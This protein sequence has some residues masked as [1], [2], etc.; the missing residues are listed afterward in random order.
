MARYWPTVLRDAWDKTYKPLGWDRKKAAVVLLAVGAI[1]VAGLQLGLA[2][3]ITTAAGY[4]WIAAPAGFAA[5]VLFVWGIIETQAKVYAE[6]SA[7]HTEAINSFESKISQLI[8]EK[9]LPEYEKW[10]QVHKYTL[11]EV[12]SLWC[13][14]EPGTIDTKE[15]KAQKRALESAIQTNK[16]PFIHKRHSGASDIE[17]QRNHPAWDTELRRTD[18]KQYALSIGQN[19]R[20]LRDA[21]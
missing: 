11:S 4:L 5:I 1:F 21:D 20:F 14:V 9:I 15:I 12:S 17:Y 19:P 18:L 3:M 13:D 8:V 6:L 7:A 2:A 10:R 16:L